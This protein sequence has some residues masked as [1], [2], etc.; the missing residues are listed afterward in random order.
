M[1]NISHYESDFTLFRETPRKGFPA[2]NLKRSKIT[3]VL[4]LIPA[5]AALAQIL[6]ILSAT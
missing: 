3:R 4:R 6:Q 5:I 1:K 2:P